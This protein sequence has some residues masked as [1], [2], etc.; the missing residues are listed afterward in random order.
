MNMKTKVLP[1]ILVLLVVGAG[2]AV[3]KEPTAATSPSSPLKEGTYSAKVA[4]LACEACPPQ[5]EKALG[6]IKG[7]TAVSVD[8]QTKTVRFTVGK[9]STVT[10]ADLQ[11]VLKAASDEMGMGADYTLHDI[12]RV[13][14]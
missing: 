12:A 3:A 1:A 14:A 7:I 9:G 11:K 10:E 6:S 13:K 5:V 8:A 2:L 4:A